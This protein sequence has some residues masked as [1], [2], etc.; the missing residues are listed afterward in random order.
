DVCPWLG[1][2]FDMIDHG[3]EPTLFG[4]INV[5]IER[6]FGIKM[7]Q[8]GWLRE[9]FLYG[10]E[11]IQ[12]LRSRLNGSGASVVLSGLS[13]EWGSLLAHGLLALERLHQSG[14][15]WDVI[16][17]PANESTVV[18]K[19]FEISGKVQIADSR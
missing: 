8:H 1:I 16:A 17:K 6:P 19:R 5:D 15:V 9:F 14:V 2:S 12:Q 4:S 7:D 10:V 3:S 11:R 18:F 13:S